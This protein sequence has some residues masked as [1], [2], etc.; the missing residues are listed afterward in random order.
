MRTE[1]NEA[2]AKIHELELYRDQCEKEKSETQQEKQELIKMLE[3]ELG[4]VE[5][6]RN[7]SSQNG[8]G[9]C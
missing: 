3:Q 6:N 2:R 8:V 4:W 1:L 5:W 9:N 7:E